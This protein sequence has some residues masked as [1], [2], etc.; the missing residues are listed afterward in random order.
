[1]IIRVLRSPVVTILFFL[2][3]CACLARADHRVPDCYERPYG[4]GGHAAPTSFEI[5]PARFVDIE[6]TLA[7]YHCTGIPMVTFGGQKYGAASYTDDPGMTFLVLGISR[8]F[9]WPIAR[10]IDFL[11]MGILSLATILSLVGI[12]LVCKTRLGRAVAGAG[13]LGVAFASARAGD[14]YCLQSAIVLAL[15]PW[16]LYFTDPQTRRGLLFFAVPFGVL[17]G[18]SNLVRSQSGTAVILIGAGLLIGSGV[19]LRRKAA[20]I[21]LVSLG[22][23]APTLY[24]SRVIARRDAF[25]QSM[26][27]SYV[28]TGAHHVFWHTAYIGFGFLQGPYGIQYLDENAI[29]KVKSIDPTLELGSP[30]Y[31][32]VLRREVWRFVKGHPWFTMY[33]LAAKFGVLIVYVLVSANAG[34][35]AAL[36]FPKRPIID[37]TFAIALAF[38]AA[39][40]VVAVPV[41]KY[42]LG[43]IALSMLWGVISIDHAI[44][45]L[46]ARRSPISNRSSELEYMY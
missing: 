5:M 21:M 34:A 33:T 8:V 23:L 31:E 22:F 32:R 41:P 6:Q 19:G 24:F 44:Q 29:A 43:L 30:G 26:Y 39:P 16:L 38:T 42:V 25:L 15:V 40:G 18:A 27:S 9:H 20:L 35:I 13:V 28:P 1:M 36:K 7:G 12:F 46:P 17:T 14:V 37:V 11:L 2:A 3:A 10:C 4:L 45:C